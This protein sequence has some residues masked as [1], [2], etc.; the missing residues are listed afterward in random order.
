MVWGIR[1]VR[2]AWMNVRTKLFAIANGSG[3]HRGHISYVTA[4][5][6]TTNDRKLAGN[7]N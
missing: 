6:R 1:G 4:A 7:E 3:S 5:I 2:I